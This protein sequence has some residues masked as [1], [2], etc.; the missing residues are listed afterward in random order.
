M[1]WISTNTSPGRTL[2][3]LERGARALVGAGAAWV[4]VLASLALCAIGVYGI[5]VARE[6]EATAGTLH[7]MAMKQLVL[8]GIGLGAGVVVA[9][10]SYRLLGQL[11][12][13][14]LALAVGLLIFVLLPFVPTSIVR[15]RNGARGWIDLGPFELQPGEVAKV[16]YVLVLAWYMRYSKTHRT[17]W[18]LVPPAI[19]T[20][21]PMGLITLEPDLGTA[22]LFVPTLFAV[23][24]A[25][26]AK[27]RHLGIIVFV[28]ALAAPLT[29]P[30]LKPH[31]KQRIVGL[32][33]QIQGDTSG[34]QDINMQSLTAQR[35]IGAGQ[36]DGIEESKSRALVHFSRLPERH[37]DMIFAVLGNR[38]G[39]FG[40]LVLLGMY[41]AW[42]VS[43]LAVA[44]T[45]REPFARLVIV[46][47]CAFI[48][49]QVFVNVGMNLGIVP[50]IGVTLPFVSY[51]G[52]S[53]VTAWMMTG[54]IFGI[55]IRRGSMPTRRSFEYA[56]QDL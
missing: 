36:F 41:A 16:A 23:L 5:D 45:I 26:G 37:N 24:V 29:Y 46:G 25:A 12:W 56:E 30:M 54:L 42:V 53:M 21:V 48:V 20:A 6:L 7:P 4:V 31:Q 3:M 32:L 38:F 11:S 50:I 51:G 15:P 14:F 33:Q 35:L 1:G 22:G 55:S 13:V 9:L 34:D 18:G 47:C 19:L 39:L 49:A 17:L 8:V 10:P 28:A 43:A 27:L 44:A 2:P 40:M 52:S